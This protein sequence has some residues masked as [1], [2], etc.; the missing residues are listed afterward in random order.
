M[1]LPKKNSS[2]YNISVLRNEYSLALIGV[3]YKKIGNTVVNRECF[4]FNQ[5]ERCSIFHS[6]MF[7]F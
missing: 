5:N 2:Y 4:P 7:V 1:L 6:S 3:A